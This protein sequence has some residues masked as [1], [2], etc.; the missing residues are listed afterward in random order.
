MSF[1]TQV[2]EVEP[3]SLRPAG[4]RPDGGFSL[5][6]AAP[7][8][9]KTRRKITITDPDKGGV[10]GTLDCEFYVNRMDTKQV[11][12]T[13]EDV[14]DIEPGD[15]G[16]IASRK[17]AKSLCLVLAS[18]DMYGDSA[19]PGFVGDDE[20]VPIDPVMM[21]MVPLWVRNQVLDAILEIV[22]PKLRTS[23]GMRKN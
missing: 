20:I 8:G 10:V 17:N 15:T 18:W 12:L 19:K 21:E 11:E 13:E 16:A 6:K 23:R 3:R 5:A 14:K 1:D 9:K 4:V 7:V 22:N 2:E